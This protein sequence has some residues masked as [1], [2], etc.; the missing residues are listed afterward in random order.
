LAKH[1][2]GFKLN[3]AFDMRAQWI[4]EHQDAKIIQLDYIKTDDNQAD[5][6]TKNVTGKRTRQLRRMLGMRSREPKSN[7][8]SRGSGTG[9]DRKRA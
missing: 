8:E 9:V 4:R 5:L 6:L 3:K 7:S 2:H 1:Q